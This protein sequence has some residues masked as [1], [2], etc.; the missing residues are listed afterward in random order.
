MILN[1][2]Q[3]KKVFTQQKSI[4]LCG[5]ACLISVCKYF[6]INVNEAEILE[7]SGTVHTGTTLLGIKESAE[8]LNLTADGYRCS[9]DELKNCDTISILHTV[10][11]DGFTHFVTCFGYNNITNQF[12]IG[13]PASGLFHCD[14]YYL[15]SIWKSK[16]LLLFDS[17]K[18][19]SK[20]D[21]DKK[22]NNYQYIFDII[23]VQ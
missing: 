21:R 7:N 4:N 20:N 3:A 9:I 18:S 17:K 1:I 22:N 23:S 6:N 8:K 10:N 15:D 2:D 14:E 16:L 11:K 12:L 19:T 5:V 13:D